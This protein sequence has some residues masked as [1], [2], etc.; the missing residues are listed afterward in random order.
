M[1]LLIKSLL[2]LFFIQTAA[3][4]DVIKN[5][6]IDGNK[7]ISK[8]TILVL[9]DIKEGMS[10]DD[11]RLNQFLNKLYETNF[12]NDIKINLENGVLKISI[13]E[14]PI[15]EE[16]EITG[17]KNKTFKENISKILSL[18][19]RQ[20]FTKVLFEN[21]LKK[22]ENNLRLSGYYFSKIKSSIVN[23]EKLNSVKLNISI[24]LGEKAKIK[25]INFIGDKKV[26]D[27]KL[28]E[29]I[30]SEEH[31]FWKFVSKNVYLNQ[32]L[33]N[34]D[35]RLLENYY[36]N[37]GY[38]NVRVLDSFAEFN[39]EGFFEL[40]YNIESGKRFLFNNLSLNIP[41]DYN[42]D[43]FD[44]ISKLFE[45]LKG[46]YYSLNSINSILEEIDKLASSKFY[47]FITADVNESIFEDKIDFTFDIKNSEKFYV[48]RI[49]ILGNYTTIEEVVRNKFIVD[50]GDPLNDLLLNKS[51]DQ[52]KSLGIFKSVEKKITNGSS[53]NLKNIDIIVEEQPTGEISVAAGIGTNGTTLGAG[54]TEKNF[55]G[56]GIKLDTNFM[57][58]DDTV[59]TK[60]NYSRPNFAYTDNTLFTEFKID[61]SDFMTDYGYEIDKIS[62]SLGTQY[63]QFENIFF[64]PEFLISAE[65]LQTSSKASSALK[66]QEGSY[67]DFYFNYGFTLDNRD[68]VYRPTSGNRS[69]FL[70]ELPIV[71]DSN[72]LANTLIFTQYL[73]L[74]QNDNMIGKGSIYFKSINS[75]DS[76]ENVRISKR[77]NIPSNRLRGFEKGKIGPK[78]NNEFVGGNYAASLNLSTE[79]P[80]I[81]NTLENVDFSYFID[82]GNVWGADFNDRLD[83]SGSIRSSTGIAVDF[84]TPIGPLNFSFSQPI[85]K[86]DSD[87]TETFR[88]N[89]GTT[90]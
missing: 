63:E 20:S 16:I 5:I 15:I 23:D 28:L 9:G 89:L 82:A 61:N 62:F 24:D 70:Q 10:A 80:F 76:D 57:I 13:L 37:L 17:I 7:R 44:A 11:S 77:V 69:S 8:N 18:K 1:N 45:E 64:S 71:S 30:A 88:F 32:S 25:K 43:D 79:L 38:Y 49:N 4:S 65:D 33:L 31:K 2:F 85:T 39:K 26:K 58:S 50:E 12:F 86:E 72:E 34:L 53:D 22:I 55:L 75:I 78:D 83:D 73:P 51:I 87:V 48:E 3:I 41:D 6:E 90:F 40:T 35:K 29:I 68:S 59:E 56:K 60:F 21:D 54:I 14:N 52:I 27:K 47:D 19:E 67:N 74:N 84:F 81:F 42:L 66:K 36:K 46:Q